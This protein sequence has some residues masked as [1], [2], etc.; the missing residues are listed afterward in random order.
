VLVIMDLPV[1]MVVLQ[2]A[3]QYQLVVLMVAVVVD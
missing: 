1:A 3:Q 2:L